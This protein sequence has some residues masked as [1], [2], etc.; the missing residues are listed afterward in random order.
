MPILLVVGVIAFWLS[1]MRVDLVL[2]PRNIERRDPR[3]WFASVIA[4]L[5]A[6]LALYALW[7]VLA[8]L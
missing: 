5:P 8:Q 2:A 6:T 1:Q 7:R 3:W 4:Y